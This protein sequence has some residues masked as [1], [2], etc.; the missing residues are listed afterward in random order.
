MVCRHHPGWK[1]HRGRRDALR[2]RA[3]G[4]NRVTDGVDGSDGVADGAD[5]APDDFADGLSNDVCDAVRDGV[6]DG[7]NEAVNAVN[8]RPLRHAVSISCG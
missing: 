5:D 8:N 2:F 3:A 7:N 1:L 4:A 6:A